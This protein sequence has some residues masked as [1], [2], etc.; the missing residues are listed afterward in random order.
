M[1]THLILVLGSCVIGLIAGGSGLSEQLSKELSEQFKFRQAKKFFDLGVKEKDPRRAIRLYTA[2][3]MVRPSWQPYFLRGSRHFALTEYEKA[4][5]DCSSALKQL[6]REHQSLSFSA[7]AAILTDRGTAYFE[8]K[9]YKKALA[10]FSTAIDRTF[11]GIAELYSLRGRTYDSLREWQLAI[12]DYNR[13]I[14]LSPN[15][16]RNYRLRAYLKNEHGDLLG[17]IDDVNRALELEPNNANAYWL[18]AECRF[19]LGESGRAVEDA[20]RAVQFDP[21]SPYIVCARAFIREGSG[22]LRGAQN[23]FSKSI[24]MEPSFAL[25]YQCRGSVR[26]RLN[27]NSGAMS[28]FNKAIFLG[29]E[30]E[31]G[32]FLRRGNLYAKIGESRNALNDF[33]TNIK[34]NATSPRAYLTRARFNQR[35]KN[36]NAATADYKIAAN[37]RAE[38]FADYYYRGLAKKPL[39]DAKGAA[40][41]LTMALALSP[42]YCKGGECCDHFEFGVLSHK[43][44]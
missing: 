23:D 9:N 14:L 3:L 19:E 30:P 36:V 1:R 35:L 25:A 20:N 31:S 43:R 32:I 17:A 26:E 37:L 18:R 7:E 6:K 16:A 22:D 34:H 2:S 40:V 27:D 24:S 44:R 33:A 41:D 39:K 5:D 12:L 21:A 15:E 4:I 38:T 13:A 8:L 28:D 11:Y 29:V 10:D 42:K